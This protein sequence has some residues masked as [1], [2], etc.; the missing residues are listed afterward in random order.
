M[1][2]NTIAA[3]NLGDFLK[4]SGINSVEVGKKSAEI[5]SKNPGRALDITA[6][7]ARAVASKNPRAALSSLPEVINFYHTGRRLNLGKLV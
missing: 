4:S 5:F 7:V 6:N 2:A 3:E 1:S